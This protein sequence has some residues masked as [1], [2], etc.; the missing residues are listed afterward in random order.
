MDGLKYAI[1]G[2]QL[3]FA[4]TGDVVDVASGNKA[5]TWRS[6]SDEKD[7]K[8]RF[9]VDGGAE[10]AAQAGYTFNNNNQLVAQLTGGDGTAFDPFTIVGG[11]EI[12]DQHELNYVL[13]DNTGTKTG[14][15]IT[16]YGDLTLAQDTNNL[17]VALA[18][19]GTAEI[20]GVNGVQSLQAE[21]NHI[22][23]FKAD[24]LLIFHAETDNEI[25]GQDNFLVVPA[26][27]DFVGSWDIQNGTL[28]FHSKIK[29]SPDS[30]TVSIGFSGTLAGVTAGFVYFADAGQTQAALNIKGEHVF[31]AANATTDLAWESSIGYTGKT[32]STQVNATSVT[33]FVSGQVL[34][35]AGD[36]TL[37][38]G[39]GQPL[40]MN[41]SLEAQYSFDTNNILIFKALIATGDQ[42]SYD[43][44]MQ[45][46]FH[47]DN[48]SLTFKA[49]Y[50]QNTT[51]SDINVS[52]GV[53]GDRS[54]IIKNVAL[55]LDISESDARL[56]LDLSF[57]VRLR[58]A[59]GVRIKEPVTG[60]TGALAAG[61]A[62]GGN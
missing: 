52:V 44:M 58:F 42:P 17:S 21:K 2:R 19:G 25:P 9:T 51:S 46:T 1:G 29:G 48:L 39:D 31:N 53:Q 57:D 54:S 5:G 10:S 35:L 38:Q 8:V 13:V 16:I 28:V 60:G 24:D 14:E 18:G 33:H 61:A 20:Q 27:I 7:N 56:K 37:Q 47:Y 55:V 15:T 11:I 50:T 59:D 62:G 30:P 22:A 6:Q 12:D 36:L 43:L 23:A 32:F 40:K 3:L 4:T 49:D 45:G 41:L 26:K 34:S